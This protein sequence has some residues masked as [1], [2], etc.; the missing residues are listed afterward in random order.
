MKLLVS[1]QMN[2]LLDHC[3]GLQEGA[4]VIVTYLSPQKKCPSTLNDWSESYPELLDM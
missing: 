4:K 2:E 3:H 1:Q